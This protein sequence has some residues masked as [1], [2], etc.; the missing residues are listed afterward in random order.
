MILLKKKSKNVI[1]E[2]KL[3]KI[4]KSYNEEK[5]RLLLG[6]EEK[7]DDNNDNKEEKEIK[8]DENI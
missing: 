6:G 5:N 1:E 3:E 7:K 2:I 4:I 8:I